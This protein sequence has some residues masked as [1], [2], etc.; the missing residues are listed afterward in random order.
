[1]IDIINCIR[2]IDWI[3]FPL[4]PLSRQPELARTL[5]KLAVR[6][7]QCR[8]FV[9][10]TTDN[11]VSNFICIPA[12]QKKEFVTKPIVYKFDFSLSVY[13]DVPSSA[14]T[15]PDL[16]LMLNFAAGTGTTPRSW[17]I[18]I[19]MLPCGASYLGIK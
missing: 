17:N 13:L 5:F 15:P 3:S 11:T 14:T 7:V 8:L 1:M 10:T 12:P 6:P 4:R 9:A 19:A 2:F 18:K 16:Q